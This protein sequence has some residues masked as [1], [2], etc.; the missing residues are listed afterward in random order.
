MYDD[1]M[2]S[3][4]GAAYVF[5]K[6]ETTGIWSQTVKLLP[7]ETDSSYQLNCGNS[8]AI[9]GNVAIMGCPRSTF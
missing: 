8:V 3:N 1:D 5:T 2:G 9:S 7:N 4:E 6:D